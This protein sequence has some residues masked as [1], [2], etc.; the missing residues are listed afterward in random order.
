MGIFVGTIIGL[1]L[2]MLLFTVV[3]AVLAFKCYSKVV[4]FEN[5]THRIEYMNP[6]EQ[7]SAPI[8]DVAAQARKAFG[9][10]EE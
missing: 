4:G 10:T 5:S 1:C 2:G 6:W 9:Y 7:N 3:C 8:D